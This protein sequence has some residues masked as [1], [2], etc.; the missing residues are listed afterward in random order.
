MPYLASPNITVRE[1]DATLQAASVSTPATAIVS[2]ATKGPINVPTYVTDPVQFATIFGDT[3][4]DYKG[5]YGALQYLHT[6][7]QCFYV[8]VSEL[9]PDQNAV[10]PYLAKTSSA[11]LLENATSATPSATKLHPSLEG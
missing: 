10:E 9:D 5:P 8:R 11:D 4:A 2:F 7:R 1:I 3:V 6:G